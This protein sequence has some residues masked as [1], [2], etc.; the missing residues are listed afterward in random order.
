MLGMLRM[1][2]SIYRSCQ[3]RW[4][5]SIAS[6]KF[7]ILYVRFV[8]LDFQAG[9]GDGINSR[10]EMECS[11]ESISDGLFSGSTSPY[12]L[13]TSTTQSIRPNTFV[14][15]TLDELHKRTYKEF[16]GLQSAQ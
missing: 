13:G 4:V 2:A 15:T 7:C 16:N 3:K 10:V 5:A 11:Q 6:G 12:A 14:L 8:G 1:T 9:L